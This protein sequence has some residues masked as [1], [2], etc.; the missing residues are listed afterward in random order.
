VV[1]HI[2]LTL[3]L[4]ANFLIAFNIALL[5][6]FR[7]LKI[8]LFSFSQIKNGLT[9]LAIGVGLSL[10]VAALSIMAIKAGYGKGYET[11]A[12]TSS[13]NKWLTLVTFLLFVG[14]SEDLFFI[15]LIQNILT[16]YLGWWAILIYLFIFIVYHYANVL[17]G[18]EDKKEFLGTLP[19]RLIVSSLLALSFY[20]TRSLVYGLIIHNTID[21]L[22]YL[23]LMIAVKKKD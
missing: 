10:I 22:S 23:A 9:L 3:L 15:G 1:K 8:E 5:I 12:S 7:L 16:P 6:I 2:G 19:I 11:F 4:R 20:L 21:T 18:V 14:L 13:L 17:S